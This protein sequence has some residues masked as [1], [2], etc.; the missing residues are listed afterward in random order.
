MR[1]HIIGM[2]C[3]PIRTGNPP[4][5]APPPKNTQRQQGE[6]ENIGDQNF[7]GCLLNSPGTLENGLKPVTDN[8]YFFGPG[9]C[10]CGS[11]GG[12]VGPGG[13]FPYR[14]NGC[15]TTT[16]RTTERHSGTEQRQVVNYRL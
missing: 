15:A 6:N 3:P 13:G 10:L 7:F 4:P 16:T 11:D 2:P 14:S 12:L 8:L 5:R 9:V 1:V